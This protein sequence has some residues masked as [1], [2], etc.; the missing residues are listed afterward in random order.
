MMNPSINT[1]RSN[2]ETVVQS[3]LRKVSWFQQLDLAAIAHQYSTPLY[4]T[5]RTQILNN[6]QEFK[7]ILGEN[8]YIYFP[9]KVNPCLATF[10]MLAEQGCGADCASAREIQLARL[11]GI[12]ASRLS[13]YSPAPDLNVAVT[14]LRDG[15]SVIIDSASKLVPLEEKLGNVPF[16]GKLFLRVNPPLYKSYAAKADYQ[17]HTSH[18]SLTSQFGLP[19]EEV[20]AFLDSTKLPFSGLHVHVGTQMDNVEIFKECVD[21]LHEL[22]DVI[23]AFTH[24]II[25]DLNLGGGL[26]IAT[27]E[28][29]HFPSISELGDALKNKFR[30]NFTY[31]MEPGNA[32]LGNATALLTRVITRKSTRGKGWAIVDVGSDQLLKVTL[33]GFAQEIYCADGTR[34]PKSGADSIA[35]PL[36]FAGDVILPETDLTGVKEGDLLLLPNTG[37][38][39][40]SIGNHFNG[41]SEPGTLMVDESHEIGLVY[42]HED[43][44][45]EPIIQSFQ[46]QYIE[47]LDL[48]PQTF[49]EQE[50]ENIRSVYLNKQCGNDTYSFHNFTRVAKGHYEMNIEVDSQVSFI[51]GPT[52]MRIISDAAVAVTID[53]IGLAEK[54][55]SVWGS[56]CTISLNSILRSK[57]QHRLSLYL[58]PM[59]SSSSS[60]KR[61]HIV[62]WQLGE[63]SGHGNLLLVF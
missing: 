3:S 50:V 44:Y 57:R 28:E 37:A 39:C 46:P 48:S 51:S 43:P 47:E 56:R 52:V 21:V 59:M 36:C 17:K 45:W 4:I 42:A 63:G 2:L 22:C 33:A 14:L 30:P 15:G 25:S 9:V 40:R 61:E 27:H 19:T 24:H 5:N 60:K 53:S 8:K 35:G 62:Y 10:K 13:Y 7:N 54:N 23:H 55:I 32:L 6:L 58:T 1:S 49:S 41:Y 34:L 29:D 20:L 12:P 26:G 16:S 18:G 31:K 38:Y 11:A